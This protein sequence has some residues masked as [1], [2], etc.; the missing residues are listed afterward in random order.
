M[1]SKL[2]LLPVLLLALFCSDIAVAERL[3]LD[4]TSASFFDDFRIVFEDT[5]DGLLQQ[6]EIVFFSGV[7]GIGPGPTDLAYTGVVYVPAIPDISTASGTLHPTLPCAQCWELTPGNFG[8]VSDGWF[9]TRWT[10]AISPSTTPFVHT[11]PC[12]DDATVSCATGAGSLTILGEMYDVEF[13]PESFN[14]TFANEDPL[15]IPNDSFAAINAVSAALTAVDGLF[16]VIGKG[17]E[18]SAFRTPNFD[19]GAIVSVT[20]SFCSPRDVNGCGVWLP[21]FSVLTLKDEVI[22]GPEI[23]GP[24]ARFSLSQLA[25]EPEIVSWHASGLL[26][27]VDTAGGFITEYPNA[28]VGVPFTLEFEFDASSPHS[29]EMAGGSGTRFRH[30]DTLQSVSLTIGG[31]KAERTQEG[32]KSIDIW[33]GFAFDGSAEPPSD[34]FNLIWFVESSQAGG[35]AGQS[36]VLRGPEHLDIFSGP[37]LPTEPSPLLTDLSTTLF[38]FNDESD[39]LVGIVDS[40][41]IAP[42]PG[43]PVDADGDGIHDGIDGTFNGAF[44]DE[45]GVFSDNFTDQHLGGT[46]RGS[47]FLRGDNAV[48]VSDDPLVGVV[49]AANGGAG[50]SLVQMCGPLNTDIF[51]V[52]LT[53][54]DESSQT[55]GSLTS[56]V[57]SG[58]VTITVGVNVNIIVPAGAKAFMEQLPGALV[59][60]NNLSGTGGPDIV[61]EEDGVPTAVGPD[62]PPLVAVVDDGL[63]DAPDDVFGRAKRGK[64]NL[65]WTPVDDVDSY[66]VFRALQS[67]G[68]YDLVGSVGGN[69]FVDTGLV[70]GETYYY[71]VQSVAGGNSSANSNEVEL[72]IPAGRRRR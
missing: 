6:E 43:V 34:G 65:T 1:H 28:A 40:V 23:Y 50:L 53:D 22:N 17:T 46:T 16:G 25:P 14:S 52:V 15:F 20:H 60:I 59:S 35:F 41:I 10:Y 9:D 30:F 37:G 70:T 51:N 56:D 71:V 32:F 8:D 69:V 55:C 42:E 54:G 61:V 49:L 19:A 2:S 45:S 47:I 24:Y 33:D 29:V 66:D 31:I 18:R 68:P 26:T 63:P 57:L 11:A 7:A 48:T 27:V 3:Q 38:Q 21:R 5:G 36:L 13:V 64:V 58:P 12:V 72:L 4:A 39:L 67:G 44:T 62:D